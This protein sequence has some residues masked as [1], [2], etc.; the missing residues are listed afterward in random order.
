[1]RAVNI[2]CKLILSADLTPVFVL[3]V[4]YNSIT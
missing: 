2:K 1:M 3:R 4:I